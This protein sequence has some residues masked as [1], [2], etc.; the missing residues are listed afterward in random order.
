MG[1]I[2]KN[3]FWQDAAKKGGRGEEKK[4]REE[5]VS[6]ERKALIKNK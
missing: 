3:Q 4:R 2:K 1:N 6:D 5:L